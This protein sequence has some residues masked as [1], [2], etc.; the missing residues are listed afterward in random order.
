MVS[1]Q[2]TGNHNAIPPYSHH[3]GGH[4]LEYIK[5]AMTNCLIL[6]RVELVNSV[7]HHNFNI[8]CPGCQ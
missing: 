1:K 4:I 3:T 5:K 7:L 2:Y 6:N 8:Q